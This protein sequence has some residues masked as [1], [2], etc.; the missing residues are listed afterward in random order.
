MP[1]FRTS[2]IIT[3]LLLSLSL[4][5]DDVQPKKDLTKDAK[6]AIDS[7]KFDAKSKKIDAEQALKLS[8]SN[9]QLVAPLA[10]GIL[11]KT[12]TYDDL[13]TLNTIADVTTERQSHQEASAGVLMDAATNNTVNLSAMQQQLFSKSPDLSLLNEQDFPAEVQKMMQENNLTTLTGK[14]NPRY[15][16]DPFAFVMISLSMPEYSIKALFNEISAS[17]PDKT[18]FVAIQGAYPKEARRTMYY[19][20]TLLP[21][22]HTFSLV[23]DPTLFNRFEVKKVPFF[24]INTEEKGWRKIMGD[25]SFSEA[26][27]RSIMHYD[28]F[29]PVAQVYPIIEP[30]LLTLMHAELEKFDTEQYLTDL[31]KNLLAEKAPRVELVLATESYEYL[32]DPTIEFEEDIKVNSESFVPR[33]TR[34]N[35]LQHMQLSKKYAIADITSPEQRAIV[36]Q[37]KQS[38]PNLVVISTI[39]PS[40]NDLTGY[41]EEFGRITQ[42]EPMLVKRLGLERIPSLVQQQ[43]LAL[44]VSVV[45][46]KPRD[47]HDNN[48]QTSPQPTIPL[49]VL[50]EQND[51]DLLNDA[52]DLINPEDS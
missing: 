27:E 46:P 9:E 51:I 37:W 41:T 14:K 26:Y 40:V 47:N 17:Y 1:L 29:E 8:E 15:T 36:R 13:D 19:L 44:H 30:N 50:P 20:S 45:A 28:D 39:Y 10:E 24:V 32:V 16:D 12:Q 11:K 48:E 3:T 23:I 2:F 49:I 38:T 34:V 18:I 25:V 4:H 35:P 21:N 33:G 22:P 31:E 42:A 6:Q 7:N 52:N 43:G 5:A